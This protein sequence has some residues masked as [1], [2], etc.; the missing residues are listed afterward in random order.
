FPF[1]RGHTTTTS[2]DREPWEF[3]ADV[4]AS[5]RTALERRYR[6]LPYIYTLFEE[7]SKTGLPVMRP[8]F[9]A[10][11]VNAA[12]RAEDHAFLLGADVLVEPSLLESGAHAFARPA[13]HWRAF[14][15]VGEDPSTD[16]AQPVLR[17][18]DGAIVPL[19]RVVQST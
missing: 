4:E 8:L 9:F 19:G 14:E 5:S 15:L 7:A 13:G 17:I 2:A 1:M 6:L 3:G 18:R 11:P 10:D 16:P 12:L